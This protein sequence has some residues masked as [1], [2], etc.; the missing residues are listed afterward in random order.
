MFTL[1]YSDCAGLNMETGVNQIGFISSY[2]PI[3]DDEHGTYSATP[4][5]YGMLAFA[6]ASRGQRVAVNCDAAGTNLTSY[7]VIDGKSNLWV[8]I[9][10][11]DETRNADASIACTPYLG[12]GTALRLAAPSLHSKSGVTLGGTEV[13]PNGE[14]KPKV[15][16]PLQSKGNQCEVRVPAASAAIVKFGDR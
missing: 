14:W 5:Y 13:G 1:A 3:G 12:N 7:A 9:V 2:S 6:Q 15:L 4:E 10:N 16:E 8:T 11:K